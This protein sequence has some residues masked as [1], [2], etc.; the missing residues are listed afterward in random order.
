MPASDPFTV[1]GVTVEANDS[2]IRQRYLELV[3]EHSPEQHPT[4]FHRIREAYEKIKNLESR[5]RYRLFE[6]GTEETIERIIEDL[7]CTAKP[8]RVP[9]DQLF[10]AI[11]AD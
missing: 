4:A 7:Q 11:Q 8:T 5:V 6:Q 3:R 10:Q 9:L 2:Q 1:L